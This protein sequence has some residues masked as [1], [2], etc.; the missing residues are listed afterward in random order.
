MGIAAVVITFLYG[1]GAGAADVTA[2]STASDNETLDTVVV[3][4]RKREE[5]LAQ[6]LI[7]ITAFSAQSLEA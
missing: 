3:T 4:A 1:E 5:S 6:V 2:T 7:S